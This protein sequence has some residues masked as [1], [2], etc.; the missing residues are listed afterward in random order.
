MMELTNN[1]IKE[2]LKYFESSNGPGYISH[3]FFPEIH[4]LI[5]KLRWH[6]NL[7]DIELAK[8][9]MQYICQHCKINEFFIWYNNQKL[10]V[11]CYEML[12]RMKE[13][14]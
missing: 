6:D 4:N 1:E 11:E 13:N 8:A 9:K 3:E 2:L 7:Y 12:E 10:C 14:K 5:K